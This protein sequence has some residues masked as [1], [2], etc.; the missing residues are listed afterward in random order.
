MPLHKRNNPYGNVNSFT[1]QLK[2]VI[3]RYKY[4]E[5]EAYCGYWARMIQTSAALDLPARAFP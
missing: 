1:L 4:A 2:G 5:K 3:L